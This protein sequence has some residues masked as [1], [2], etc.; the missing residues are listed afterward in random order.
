MKFGINRKKRELN[1]VHALIVVHAV[2]FHSKVAETSRILTRNCACLNQDV[3]L[4]ALQMS[5]STDV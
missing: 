5:G 1:E 3:A 2:N 4:C